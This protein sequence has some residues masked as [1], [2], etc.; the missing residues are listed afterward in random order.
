MINRGSEWHR[1][2][3]HI[4]APGTLMNDQFNG[5]TAWE[6]YLQA[7]ELATPMIEAIAV[8]DYY[9]TDTYERFL[10]YKKNGRLPNVRLVFPNV[11]LRL[12]AA[13]S[14]GGFVNLHLFV[15]PDDPEHIERLQQFLTR[16]HF[17]AHQE[18]YACTHADLTRLGKTADPTITDNHAALEY[19]VSQFKVS[20]RELR[21]EFNASAWA[22]ANIRV[23]VAGGADDGTSGVRGASDQTLRGEIESFADII[24]AGGPAQREFWLGERDL[25][26]QQIRS[27]YGGLKPCLHGSDAHRLDEVATPFGDRFSWIKGGLDFDSLR[28]ACIEPRGRAHVGVEPPKS[29]TPSQVVAGLEVVDAPWL[30]RQSCR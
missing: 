9:V 2:E 19:G 20:F 8:T 7:L 21:E 23:A 3:P 25:K 11:E 18:R 10:E 27:R 24:L 5:P 1:W 30:R 16:L 15:S 4:H 14:K 6:D 13:T 28:Q 26:P 29:A 22:Q 17:D 12:D